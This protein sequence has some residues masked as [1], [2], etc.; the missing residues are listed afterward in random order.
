M[1]GADEATRPIPYD[2]TL[3][4]SLRAA[5]TFCSCLWG[6]PSHKVFHLRSFCAIV[7]FIKMAR[8]SNHHHTTGTAVLLIVAWFSGGSVVTTT[9]AQFATCP[10]ARA[11]A[12]DVLLE[13]YR[14][15]S[16]PSSSDSSE[17]I[18][19]IVCNQECIEGTDAFTIG[20]VDPCV[21]QALDGYAVERSS[22][23]GAGVGYLLSSAYP[24]VIQS[25]THT[26]SKGG[27]AAGT[28]LSNFYTGTANEDGTSQPD[29]GSSCDFTFNDKAC[30]CEQIYC[31]TDETEYGFK[32]D[33]SSLPGGSVVNECD[34]TPTLTTNSTPFEILFF[35]PYLPSTCPDDSSGG[36]VN[37]SPVAVPTAAAS[38]P[39][40]VVAAP[41]T[42][43]APPVVAPTTV[44]A[45]SVAA[46]ANPPPVPATGLAPTP[47]TNSSLPNP[48]AGTGRPFSGSSRPSLVVGSLGGWSTGILVVVVA[49]VSSTLF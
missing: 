39:P 47:V 4:S 28:T 9:M 24:I 38:S 8:F 37:P 11:F 43:V 18:A 33:C 15:W 31:D 45:P 17:C 1:L 49:V 23:G 34:S 44:V 25:Y 7:E 29:L 2:V 40:P 10:N 46:T 48:P 36:A 41:T 21:S 6:T 30:T 13:R 35:T 14:G 22:T 42:V 27:V 12:T 32:I 3:A 16:C 5:F 19:G 26:F 20:C